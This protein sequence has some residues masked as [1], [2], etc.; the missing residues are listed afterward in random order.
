MISGLKRL[1]EL[2]PAK[3]SD[4]YKVQ[5]EIYFPFSNVNDVHRLIKLT[6]GH[7]HNKASSIF[8]VLGALGSSYSCSGSG[9]RL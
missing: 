7:W 3:L 4:T 1:A 5:W 8:S 9:K 2:C 6:R